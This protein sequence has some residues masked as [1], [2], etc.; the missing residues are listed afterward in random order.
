MKTILLSFLAAIATAGADDTV[1][2]TFSWPEFAAAGKLK[3]GTVVSQ[4]GEPPSLK[5]EN[6]IPEPL[7]ATLLT[8][9]QPKITTDFYR[10]EGEVRYEG[11]TGDGFLEMW[12]YFPEGGAYFS[13]TLGDT[14][15][16]GKLRGTSDWRPFVLPFNAQGAKSHPN[17]LVI[18]L[19]LPGKGTVFLRGLK[20]VQMTAF[21]LGQTGAW[22]SDRMAGWVGGIG[23]GLIGCVGSWMEWCARRGRSRGFV[24]WASKVFIIFGIA[25]IAVGVAAVALHQPYGV[26]YGLLLVGLLCVG[27]FAVR[28]RGYQ[29]RYRELELRRM[30]AL[31]VG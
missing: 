9:E 17:K 10:V 2:A 18:S 29:A 3:T 7:Q 15:P 28:L 19:H 8:I 1:L 25:S 12:N 16:M 6:A 27:I 24:L 5:I 23:G 21:G 20:L 11:V 13:R 14:G 26:W 4:P 30:A 31:D 22:W